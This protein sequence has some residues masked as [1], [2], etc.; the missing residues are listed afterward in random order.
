MAATMRSAGTPART[1]CRRARRRLRAVAAGA[2]RREVARQMHVLRRR[3]R[4]QRSA[5]AAEQPMGTVFI[6]SPRRWSDDSARS[7]GSLASARV[8]AARLADNPVM[9][10]MTSTRSRM[11]L[12][13]L[14][15]NF[16]GALLS[17]AYFNAVGRS[18]GSRVGRRH[19]RG[20]RFARRLRVAVHRPA[21]AVNRLDA[22]AATSLLNRPAASPANRRGRRAL[23]MPA[24]WR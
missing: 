2:G 22:T 23:L 11:T 5:S 14:L 20:R 3:Q 12:L 15:G 10:R 17:F 8:R 18:T 4:R 6:G 24:S 16:G 7:A 9:A 13:T 1:S 21:A 19:R